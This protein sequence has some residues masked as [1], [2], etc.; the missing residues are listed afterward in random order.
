MFSYTHHF[1]ALSR[2]L[3]LSVGIFFSIS[4]H[5]FAQKNQKENFNQQ[6]TFTGDNNFLLFNGDDG[7]YTSGVFLRYDRLRSKSLHKK[8]VFS[9]ELGQQ[10]YTAYS[11]KIL[12]NPTSQFPGGLSQIDRPVAGYLFAKSSLS[13]VFNNNILLSVGVSAGSV[14]NH[15]YG[16]EIYAFWHSVVGV[17]SHWNWVWDYQVED[18]LGANAHVTVALPVV[19]NNQRFQLTP[20]TEATAG[21]SFTELTQAVVIQYGRLLKMH[22]SSFWQ[23]RLQSNSDPENNTFELFLYLKPAIT[24]QLYNATIEGSRYASEQRGITDKPMSWVGSYTAGLC[25]AK[26]RYSLSYQFVVQTREAK[27]QF[28]HQSHA[29]I[30]MTYRF[31]N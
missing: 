8:Q 20:V 18:K 29:S 3:G 26:A 23:T 9:F 16:R 5:I 4:T 31:G 13:T 15:S 19:H 11:R 25:F 10:L 22:N 27:R 7:Y 2:M 17:K 6:I 21:T 1:S 30:S 28:H 24:Y 12:P 14:G